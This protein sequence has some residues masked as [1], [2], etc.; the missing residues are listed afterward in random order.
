MS[1]P[2]DILGN[3]YDYIQ[4]FYLTLLNKKLYSENRSCIRQHIPVLNYESYIR[5]M[6]RKD[7]HF[8]FRHLLLE[9]FTKWQQLINFKYKNFTFED[10]V[11]YIIYLSQEHEASR[12]CEMITDKQNKE[13]KKRHKNVRVRSNTWSN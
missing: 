11:A 2:D 9:S 5:Q 4:P 8:V 13:G 10:Y 6:V 7:N 3:I 1:L 12:V